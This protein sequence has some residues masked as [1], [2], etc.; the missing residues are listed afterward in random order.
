MPSGWVYQLGRFQPAPRLGLTGGMDDGARQQSP[1]LISSVPLLRPRGP[2]PG[3]KFSRKTPSL[4]REVSS[5]E[6]VEGPGGRS[7]L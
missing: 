1:V 3:P 2:D 4:V 7:A 6:Y 5:A